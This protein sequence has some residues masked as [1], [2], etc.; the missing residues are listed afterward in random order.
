MPEGLD[1]DKD[2]SERVL[3]G[4]VDVY[5]GNTWAHHLLNIGLN[6]SVHREKLAYLIQHE[7]KLLVKETSLDICWISSQPQRVHLKDLRDRY[8]KRFVVISVR[9]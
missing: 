8:E 1:L 6:G 4:L 5:R 7:E 3:I 9:Y 2:L